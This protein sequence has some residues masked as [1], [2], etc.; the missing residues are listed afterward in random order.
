MFERIKA[1][2]D[3]WHDIKE[4]DSLSERDL[5]DLGMSRD[6]VQAFARMPR[7]ISDRVKHMAAVFGISDAEL[8]SNHEAYIDILSTCG[9]CRD[10]AK[11]AHLLARGTD[12][13]PLEASE[14]CLNAETFTA[15]AEQPAA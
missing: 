11:C 15:R 5:N 14:F 13:S 7:D 10:R 8:Q 9:G 4:I 12:A 3:R 1:L 2:M 6:Q